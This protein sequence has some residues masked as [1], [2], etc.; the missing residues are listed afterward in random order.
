MFDPLGTPLP[1]AAPA[2]AEVLAA[3]GALQR[4]CLDTDAD[5]VLLDLLSGLEAAR[6]QLAAVEAAVVAQVQARGLAGLRA[7]SSTA[8]LLTQLLRLHPREAAARVRAAQDL[9]PRRGLTGERLQPVFPAVADALA[10]GRISARHAAVITRTVD[11]LPAAV[12]A[13]HDRAVEQLLVAEAQRCNPAQ[14]AVLSRRISDT[15]DP[16][17]TLSDAEYRY[18]RRYL[19]VT[20]RADGSAHV[21]AE[22]EPDC[23]EALLTVLDTLAR[24]DPAATTR[25]ADGEGAQA[26]VVAQPDLRTPGQRRH[27]GLRDGLLTLIRS[28]QLPACGGVSSTIVLTVTADDFAAGTGVAQT[29]HG[30]LIPTADVRRMAGGAQLIPVLLSRTKRIEAY[31]RT[32]RFFTAGQRLAMI[33]RDQGCSFPDCTVPPAWCEAHHVIDWADGGPTTVDNGAL[34]C[35]YHHREHPRLGWSCTMIN[36]RPHW[37]APSWLDPTRTPRIN[38]A[39]HTA[40]DLAAPA[41]TTPSGCRRSIRCDDSGGGHAAAGDRADRTLRRADDGIGDQPSGRVDEVGGDTDADAAADDCV[42]PRRA[43]AVLDENPKVPV[44]QQR[45]ARDHATIRADHLIHPDVVS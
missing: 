41:L 14:L 29:G 43:V 5:D 23:A 15:L 11:A 1:P 6:S 44:G 7:C 8:S 17:G 30:A 24:P 16:D 38:T 34:L 18:R 39:H 4:R 27:D 21:Q 10:A 32:R 40:A 12:A 26:D 2:A 20:Q 19:T 36:G 9:G 37:T 3:I 33:S 31:G 25:D 13:E 28:D 45:V 22:L 35:G 42:R